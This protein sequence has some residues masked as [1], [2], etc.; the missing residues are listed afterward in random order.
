MK[1]YPKAPDTL[2]CKPVG[3]ESDGDCLRASTPHSAGAL[4][5]VGG[6]ERRGPEPARLSPFQPGRWAS[7]GD[8]ACGLGTV[9]PLCAPCVLSVARRPCHSVLT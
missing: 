7:A 1:K 4:L 5:G 3:S 6:R 8:A 9:M 2:F